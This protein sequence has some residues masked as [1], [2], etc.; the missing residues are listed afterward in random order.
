M[1]SNS[2]FILIGV[3]DAVIGGIVIVAVLL[4]IVVGLFVILFSLSTKT[5]VIINFL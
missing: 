4:M 1:K 2:I 3:F 5:K